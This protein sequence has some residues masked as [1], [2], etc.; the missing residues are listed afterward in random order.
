[1]QPS[2]DS[3]TKAAVLEYLG[4]NQACFLQDVVRS[5]RLQVYAN[6]EDALRELER[7]DRVL[8]RPH[9][10]GDPHLAGT[11]LRIVALVDA[12]NRDDALA[13]AISAIDKTWDVW[14]A[15]Y[16]ANHRCT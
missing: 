16:L 12:R 6:V 8:I 13:Q 9:S 11:D 3:P 7:D 1:M 15:N 14:L 10:A 2:R 4:A 5:R